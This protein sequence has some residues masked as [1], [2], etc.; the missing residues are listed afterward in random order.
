MAGRSHDGEPTHGAVDAATM[1]RDLVWV[2]DEEKVRTNSRE[3]RER[4]REL[5]LKNCNLQS[6]HKAGLSV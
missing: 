3:E 2:P 5:H 6:V 4:E 1:L